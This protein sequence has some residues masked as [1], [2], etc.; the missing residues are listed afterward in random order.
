MF[1]SSHPDLKVKAFKICDFE[2]FLVAHKYPFI[3]FFLSSDFS[4]SKSLK[5]Q[6]HVSTLLKDLD[7]RQVH[8]R[9]TV[10]MEIQNMLSL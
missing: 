7:M 6:S 1:E 4:S 3:A 2:G 5:S 10:I 8:N 9:L